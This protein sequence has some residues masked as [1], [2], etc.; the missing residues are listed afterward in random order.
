MLFARLLCVCVLCACASPGLADIEV[1]PLAN[2]ARAVTEPIDMVETSNGDL[3]VLLRVMKYGPGRGLPSPEITLLFITPEGTV[4][5]RLVLPPG[6]YKS[7]AAYERGIAL[8]QPS[9]TMA[10]GQPNRVTVLRGR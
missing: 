4:R 5:R 1:V 8:L 2:D 3:V 6:N 9:W 10:P 7:M